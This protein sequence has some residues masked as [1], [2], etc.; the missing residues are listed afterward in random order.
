ME[1]VFEEVDK[2]EMMLLFVVVM[3]SFFIIIGFLW[4]NDI[5]MLCILSLILGCGKIKF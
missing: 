4:K 3:G 5:V 2:G 1:K